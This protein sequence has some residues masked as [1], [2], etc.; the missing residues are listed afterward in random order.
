MTPRVIL[1]RHG[2]STHPVTGWLDTDGLH[3]WFADYDAAGIAPNDEPPAA[4]RALAS[5]AGLV[6]ASDLRRAIESARRLVPETPLQTSPLLRETPLRIPVLRVRLPILGWALAVGVGSVI[7]R[8]RR[9]PHPA[10]F[11]AQAAGAAEWL[12]DL[13]ERHGTVLAVTHSIMRGH[14]AT[15][16]VSAGWRRA[17]GGGRSTHWS[18]WSFA[19]P[20]RSSSNHR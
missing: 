10:E 18:A 19:R 6:V 1:V 16:L 5:S 7:Q 13:A 8:L 15:A 14:I 20:S 17:P 12:G 2:R 9:A 4:L 3:R 11:V